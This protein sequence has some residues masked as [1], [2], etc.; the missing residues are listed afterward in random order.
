M[1][2]RIIFDLVSWLSA[3]FGEEVVHQV[4]YYSEVCMAGLAVIL[5]VCGGFWILFNHE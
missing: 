1:A 3:F 2:D 5:A 4:E